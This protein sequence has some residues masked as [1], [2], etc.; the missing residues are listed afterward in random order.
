[1]C[2]VK[3]IISYNGT[4]TMCAVKDIISYNGTSTMCGVK[5]LHLQNQVYSSLSFGSR[6]QHGRILCE[7]EIMRYKECW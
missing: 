7:F 4:S 2:G 3:D 6:I 5:E 1:M